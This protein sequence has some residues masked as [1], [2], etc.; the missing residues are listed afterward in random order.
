MNKNTQKPKVPPSPT[1]I[2]RKPLIN[3]TNVPHPNSTTQPN[4]ISRP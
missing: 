3:I 2:A 4:T 1:T